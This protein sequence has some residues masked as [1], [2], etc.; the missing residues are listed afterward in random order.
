M[1]LLGS[2]TWGPLYR[3]LLG[4]AQHDPDVAAGVNERFISPQAAKLRSRLKIAQDQGQVAPDF[5]LA[6]AM[7]L[8][9]GPLYFQF[10]ITQETVTHEFVDNVFQLLFD[11]MGSPA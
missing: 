2:P 7:S 11:A 6:F 1:D 10:L 4:E 5:D 9:S 8:L 3:A